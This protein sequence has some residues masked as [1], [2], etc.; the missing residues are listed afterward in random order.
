MGHQDEIYTNLKIG[1]NQRVASGWPPNRQITFHNLIYTVTGGFVWH[2]DTSFNVAKIHLAKR[3]QILFLWRCP[4]PTTLLYRPADT[5]APPGKSCKFLRQIVLSL[6]FMDKFSL[7][8]ITFHVLCFMFYVFRFWFLF[9]IYFF[10]Y[11]FCFCFTFFR[12]SWCKEQLSSGAQ[13]V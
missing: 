13:A 7:R 12:H 1:G 5:I 3:I 4:P 2:H 6:K 8:K 10:L 9:P 11:V